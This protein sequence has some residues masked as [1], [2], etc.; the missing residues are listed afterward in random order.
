MSKMAG[1][2]TAK[3]KMGVI[4][5]L[6]NVTHFQLLTNAMERA[7]VSISRG[8]SAQAEITLREA[9]EENQQIIEYHRNNSSP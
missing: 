9:L 4:P 5:G 3:A 2:A 1:K 6:R 7:I 8:Q